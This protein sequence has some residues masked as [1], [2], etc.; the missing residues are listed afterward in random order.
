MES[1]E[2]SHHEL[3][4]DTY[5]KRFRV[6]NCWKPV[7]TD[8]KDKYLTGLAEILPQWAKQKEI[9]KIIVYGKQD[10]KKYFLQAGYEEESCIEGF[11][12]GRNAY[13]MSWFLNNR[14]ISHNLQREDE[15]LLASTKE[16][17]KVL[18]GT[19]QKREFPSEYNLRP[20]QTKDMNELASIFRT[21]FPDYYPCPNSDP[22][23]LLKGMEK[24]DTYF[25]VLEVQ[26]ILSSNLSSKIIGVGSAEIDFVNKSAELTDCVTLPEYRGKNLMFFLLESIEHH[27]KELDIPFLYSLTRANSPSMN[28]TIARLGFRYRGRQKNNCFIGTGLED[29]NVWVK[30]L[31]EVF[32]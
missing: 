4:D 22:N 13:L 1:E 20:A 3:I 10:E 12:N 25:M 5:N 19:L 9:T 2:W 17:E 6:I 28:I 23:Y 11:F 8:G 26:E 14:Q 27:L 16:L 24:G 15:I 31:K 29:I 32:D 18:N 21:A 30:P 7:E